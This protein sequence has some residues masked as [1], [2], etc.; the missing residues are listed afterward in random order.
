MKKTIFKGAG[1][2]IT[3]PL[4]ADGINYPEFKK[5][6]EFQIA[7]HT[8][9]IVVAGTSGE[10]AT[11][12]DAEHKEIIEFTVK[13]VNG[14]VP[15]IAGTGSNDTAYSVQ[16]SKF[17]KKVG[18]DAIL[19][20]TPYYNKCTQKGLIAHFTKIADNV[21]I[22][23]I[24]YNVPSRTG[25]NI[26]P[27]TYAQLAKHPNIVAAKEANGDL[28]SILTTRALCGDN[29]TVYSGNDDQIIPILSLG[30]KGVI[31]VLANI[32]PQ[33]THDICANY[34][35]GKVTDAA[36]AQIDFEDLIAALFCEVNPIPVKTALKFMGY[37]MGN[38]RLP[39]TE[40]EPA[41]QEKLKAVMK[42]H[43]II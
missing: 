36:N 6:I 24:L 2:A 29:L 30:G 4:T 9:A 10:A 14:R 34:L 33:A 1:V 19:S 17:A 13:E 20:V 40:M 18:V 21:N 3:T 16:L 42:K 27:Q 35:A 39:L 23:M 5:L 32:L 41:N 8:D 15:V 25:V 7:N 43:H 12:S 26:Q 38:V 22:P 11:M 31:S 28:S 37:N